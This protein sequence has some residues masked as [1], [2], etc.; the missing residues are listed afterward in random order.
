MKKI[1]IKNQLS[2]LQQ[3]QLKLLNDRMAELKRL[4]ANRH[5][6][7]LN[8]PDSCSCGMFGC[9]RNCNK[10]QVRNARCQ[11]VSSFDTQEKNLRALWAEEDKAVLEIIKT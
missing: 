7:L 11:V 10:R 1:K 6:T 4:Q 2:Q 5:A 3:Y 9:G 8:Y